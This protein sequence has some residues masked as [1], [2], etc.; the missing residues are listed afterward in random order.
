MVSKVASDEQILQEADYY[1]NNDVTIEQASGDLGVSKRTFQLHLKKLESIDPEKFKL[2]TDK[3]KSNERQ[4]KIK[5]GTIGK[6]GP[7]W[8]EKQAVAAANHMVSGE[9]TYRY[10]ESEL[11]IPKSTLYDMVHKAHL[12][13]ETDSFL[14]TL[15]QANKRGMSVAEY[16]EAIKREHIATDM[17]AQQANREISSGRKK[18]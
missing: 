18:A 11:D 16:T 4:G 9:I 8:T 12:D 14:Y 15:S 7:S 5:G 17:A 10:G 6:R 2:V 13:P 1:L 3:K